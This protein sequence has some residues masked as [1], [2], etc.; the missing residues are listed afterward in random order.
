[1]VPSQDGLHSEGGPGHLPGE[2]D[3]ESWGSLGRT[4]SPVPGAAS[5]CLSVLRMDI[6]LAKV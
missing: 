4:M 2:A 3:T 1:V 6:H 5:L